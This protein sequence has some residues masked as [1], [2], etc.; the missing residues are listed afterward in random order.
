MWNFEKLKMHFK[1][2][3]FSSISD[4]TFYQLCFASLIKNANVWDLSA[5]LAF[6]YSIEGAT[7]FYVGSVT[8]FYLTS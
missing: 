5:M 1:T 8:S 4:V 6:E 2:A 3:I 7:S